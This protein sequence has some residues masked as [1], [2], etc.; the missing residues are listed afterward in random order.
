MIVSQDKPV[1]P[2]AARCRTRAWIGYVA[3]VAL[4]LLALTLVLRLWR[5][6]LTIPFTYGWDSSYY[7]MVVRGT[8][9]NGWYLHNPRVGAPYGFDGRDFP[10]ADSLHVG[11]VWL[12]GRVALHPVLTCNLFFLATFPLTTLTS[13]LVL[14]RF[15]CAWGPAILSSLLYTFLPYHLLRA[16]QL[17]FAAYFHVPLMVLVVLWLYR[18]DF[19][20]PE[21]SHFQ[22]RGGKFLASVLICVLVA[23][24]GVYYA[25]FGC[26]FL[27][28]A[29]VAAATARRSAARLWPCGLLIAAVVLGGAANGIPYLQARAELGPNTGALRRS[30]A[31]AEL[32]GLKVAQLLLPVTNHRIPALASLKARYNEKMP[33]VTDND[34]STLG[35]LGG[36]GFLLL[37]ARLFVRRQGTDKSPFEALSVLNL[38]A[39]LLA[40]IGGFG[41]FVCAALPEIRA[42]NRISV[43]IGFFALFAL[44]LA[45]SQLQHRFA[46]SAGRR[47]LFGGLLG[48]LLVGGVLDQTPDPLPFHAHTSAYQ[49]DAAF[50][51]AIEDALPERAMVF[52]L[53]YTPYPENP[54]PHRMMDYDHARGYLHSRT[55]KWSYP[56]MRG[57]WGDTWQS[58]VSRK[59]PEE[60]VAS[61]AAAGFSGLYVDRFGYADSAAELER[62]LDR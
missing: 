58:A 28:V 12:L 25:F 43:Y 29:G 6:D 14:R 60:L 10:H 47:Y 36:I 44:A 41:F 61:L 2:I 33:L 32:Y 20:G 27:A 1:D 5:V 56:T 53:P 9:E 46:A 40:A 30:P 16:C 19:F 18:D 50:I 31:G 24:G 37:I 48:L 51:H 42:F 45:L 55:L 39:V 34:F 17:F 52:Q 21:A 49:E 4:C 11:L 23:C 7:E 8:L 38:F 35:V 62:D 59:P 13:L 26:G 15:G 3:A 54:P 22:W 57:R